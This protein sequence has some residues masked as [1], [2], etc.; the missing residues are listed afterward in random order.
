MTLDWWRRRDPWELVLQR[1]AFAALVYAAFHAQLPFS[2]Q[3]FPVG[4]ATWMDFTFLADPSIRPWVDVALV[5]ALAAY[6]AGRAMPVATGVMA[7]LYIAAGALAYSQGMLEHHTQLLALVL[8]AQ[9]LAYVQAS[10]ATRWTA[11]RHA[12][13]SH[14]TIEVIAAAYVMTGLLKVMLS[15]GEW[16]AQLP[17]VATDVAKAHGQEFCTT[18]EPWLLSRAEWVTGVILTYPNL[19]RALMAPALF[20]ELAAPAAVLGR[21]FAMGIGLGLFVMH[22]GIDSVMAIR[23]LEN[24]ALVLIY[25]VNVPYLAVRLWRRFSAVR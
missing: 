13:A 10:V 14:Y 3:P 17:M 23:F 7:A 6:V 24:E 25:L 8:L 5:V 12:L 1:I 20:F 11:D 4:I 21:V 22:R 15:H 16:V 2:E 18:G 9:C 19:T